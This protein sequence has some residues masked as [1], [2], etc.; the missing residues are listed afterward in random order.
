[1]AQ[2]R[3]KLSGYHS[4]LTGTSKVELCRYKVSS[5]M[6][7]VI[8]MLVNARGVG[9]I[10]QLAI[11]YDGVFNISL[12]F[13]GTKIYGE[14]SPSFIYAYLD[15]DEIV[16]CIGNNSTTNNYFAVSIFGA[17]SGAAIEQP[18]DFSNIG[19]SRTATITDTTAKYQIG[20]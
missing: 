11:S 7:T 19:T 18:L 14:L 4:R 9:T 2:V 15:N 5:A 13:S 3:G 12:S 10:G 20:A 16:I 1:M 6:N 17:I 8:F